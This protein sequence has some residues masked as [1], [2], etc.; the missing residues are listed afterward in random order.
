MDEANDSDP[1]DAQESNTAPPDFDELLTCKGE[2]IRREVRD[3]SE[4][5]WARFVTAVHR[6]HSRR[7]IRNNPSLSRWEELV[8]LHADHVGEAHGGSLFLPWHRL[9]L[10]TLENLLRRED[11]EVVLPY[12]DWSVDAADAARSS[13]W[14]RLGGSTRS[15][16]AVG[17]TCVPDGPFAELRPFGSCV[18]RGFAAGARG[19][20]PPLDGWRVLRALVRRR[21]RF[22]IFTQALEASHAAPHASIGGHM[23]RLRDA[24][25]DVIFYLHHAF[26]DLLYARWQYNGHG[27][28]GRFGG[29]HH[30]FH[31]PLT[32]KVI[33]PAFNRSVQYAQRLKCVNY[34]DLSAAFVAARSF[35]HSSSTLSR[36][37]R[38]FVETN[39]LDPRRLMEGRAFLLQSMQ[40]AAENGS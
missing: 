7:G 9:Y 28:L 21:A 39:D 16:Y 24:P 15:R 27:H 14:R 2:R 35:S 19:G 22:E 10:L 6:L 30:G 38:S 8:Q 33:L 32:R 37:P 34:K 3:M 23:A 1:K 25:R 31:T 26:V 36:V 29:S 20:M 18:R 5:D 17:A 40:P 11:G 13:V 12:W 4:E